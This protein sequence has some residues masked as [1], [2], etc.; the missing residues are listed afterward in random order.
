M[1]NQL[2]KILILSASLLGLI[3]AQAAAAKSGDA[4]G[5]QVLKNPKRLSPVA[6]YL[7]NVPHPGKPQVI[8]VDGYPAIQDGRT[9]YVAGTNLTGELF[10]DIYLISYNEGADDN[11]QAIF[12]QFLQNWR[13]NI[14]VG[15][16]LDR[17][18][19]KRDMHRI[20]DLNDMSTL[21]NNYK[22]ATGHF[23]NLQAGTFVKGLSFSVW[24]SWEATLGNAVST[25]LPV[26]PINQFQGCVAPFDSVTCWDEN[27]SRF[28]CPPESRVYAYQSNPAGTE[29]KLFTNFEYSGAG[30][31]K[32][33]DF[34]T[35]VSGSCFNF[36]AGLQTDID[37]D[38]VTN[39]LDNCPA[40]YNPVIPGYDNGCK[41]KDPN[42]KFSSQQKDADCDGSGDACDKCPNDASND[43]DNDGV[44]GNVDNC[45]TIANRDQKDLDNDKIG[46]A[47]DNQTCGNSKREGSEECDKL[48]GVKDH[49][50]CT[51]DCKLV[52]LGY[53]GDGTVQST[54][55]GTYDGTIPEQCEI[56]QSG[57]VSCIVKPPPT[58]GTTGAFNYPGSRPRTCGNDC[59]WKFTGECVP[60]C[61]CAN[62]TDKPDNQGICPDGRQCIPATCGDG[63]KNGNEE[64]D[65]TT[66][67]RDCTL[68]L[69]V[70]YKASELRAC[71]ADCTWG[72][73]GYCT[74]T[75]YCGDKKINGPEDCDVGNLN[76][77]RCSPDYE[78]SCTFCTD[79]CLNKTLVGPYCG[80][81]RVNGP[82]ACDTFGGSG[83][84]ATDQYDCT[85]G[86]YAS[87]G[88]RWSGGYR[89]DGTINYNFG[90]QCDCGAVGVSRCDSGAGVTNGINRCI[91]G[92]LVN[93]A[94][95]GD[96]QTQCPNEA[97][98]KEQC[99]D[100]NSASG[101]GCYNC[102]IEKYSLSGSWSV[103]G[104]LQTANFGDGG[105][106]FSDKAYGPA[107][108]PFIVDAIEAQVHW[109]CPLTLNLKLGGGSVYSHSY[110]W[111]CGSGSVNGNGSQYFVTYVQFK[112]NDVSGLKS[113]CDTGHLGPD[114]CAKSYNIPSGIVADEIRMNALFSAVKGT[115]FYHNQKSGSVSISTD[116][117]QKQ[118]GDSSGVGGATGVTS[119]N[120][121][122][123]MWI[124]G[125]SV[126]ACVDANKNGTC[127]NSEFVNQCH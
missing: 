104:P 101:D 60:N 95:C 53:C 84:G 79:E 33:G 83:S 81:Q 109:A 69:N 127:D 55:S 86:T 105:Q 78:S 45:P 16:L 118:V 76:G 29:I 98:Q 110:D 115:L 8:E 64:C 17:D 6:W 73:F 15:D 40:V 24:P 38:G 3:F 126:M 94:R 63:R 114:D 30:T 10:A 18:K 88:C 35:I 72:P 123:R 120:S 23:P 124:N 44:C 56:G 9:V 66:E 57:T 20:A 21:L 25:A 39:D 111:I 91:N 121:Q 46:D 47:C 31:W 113:G 2:R 71:K 48:S 14:N 90:E 112:A 5:V 27:S 54:I 89:G 74:T 42:Y 52:Q 26:D 99:D 77:N 37:G 22:N 68:K 117:G 65:G 116:D 32:T 92:R 1:S 100:G 61:F 108:Q 67:L 28:M 58:S 51:A 4:I 62:P 50:R 122:I 85:G 34:T 97:G 75:E 59:Q 107:A 13:F 87:G 119:S 125:T 82:E 49:Q 12:T 11:T 80:D 93:I 19:L 43:I 96:G 36:L 106:W 70:G 41:A 7:E 102:Q 103:L